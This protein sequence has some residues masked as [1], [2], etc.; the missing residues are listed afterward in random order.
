MIR[1]GK[2]NWRR[3]RNSVNVLGRPRTSESWA[4]RGKGNV[5][6]RPGGGEREKKE[7]EKG[8]ILRWGKRISVFNGRITPN[9]WTVFIKS[10]VVY[11]VT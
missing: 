2:T 5:W 1:E 11:E 6:L 7:K 3:I 9:L 8:D 10:L 4:Y